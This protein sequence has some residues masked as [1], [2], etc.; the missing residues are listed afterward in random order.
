MEDSPAPVRVRQSSTSVGDCRSRGVRGRRRL[1]LDEQ[2]RI[3][4][5]EAANAPHQEL[6]GDETQH[7]LAAL[8]QSLNDVKSGQTTLA[9]QMSQLQRRI[10]AKNST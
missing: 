10:N 9:D 4:V 7:T 5:L 1:H 3:E 6:N 8:Q 2:N